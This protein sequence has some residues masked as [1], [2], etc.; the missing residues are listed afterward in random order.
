MSFLLTC[1][2]VKKNERVYL[3][4]NGCAAFFFFLTNKYAG[5]GG[6]ELAGSPRA[7]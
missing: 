1:L 3:A 7:L 2:G 5:I 6:V 4:I